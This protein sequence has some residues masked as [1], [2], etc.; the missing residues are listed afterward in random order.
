MYEIHTQT[1]EEKDR[2]ITLL[3]HTADSLPE[4]ELKNNDELKCKNINTLQEALV[5]LDVQVCAV[6]EEKLRMCVGSLTHQELL[7]Q[8]HTDTPRGATLL[9]AAQAEVVNLLVCVMSLLFGYHDV[10]QCDKEPSKKRLKRK[11][12]LILKVVDCVQSLM[13]ILY[14]LQATVMIQDGMYEVQKLLILEEET[15]QAD[16]DGKVDDGSL[17]YSNMEQRDTDHSEEMQMIKRK[18]EGLEVELQ[19]WAERTQALRE[20]EAKVE[21]ER[22]W[23]QQE[24]R[25][26]RKERERM[27]RKLR[28]SQQNS[29]NRQRSLSFIIPVEK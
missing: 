5:S 26:I 1:R 14:S 18:K 25:R 3:Q 29:T 15:L 16:T 12:H 27:E 10:N 4:N 8:T 22:R 6:L 20:E 2:W 21:R 24:E 13:Q 17:C 11:E 19:Q 7:V 23:I 9:S 28:L